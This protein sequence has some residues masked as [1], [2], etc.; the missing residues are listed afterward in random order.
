VMDSLFFPMKE[1]EKLSQHTC[2]KKWQVDESASELPEIGQE[3]SVLPAPENIEKVGSFTSRKETESKY[4]EEE[5]ED[6][7][8]RYSDTKKEYQTY[9]THYRNKVLL[10]SFSSDEEKE[11]NF[12]SSNLGFSGSD[13]GEEGIN[14]KFYF[15]KEEPIYELN[16]RGLEN[17]EHSELEGLL[18]VYSDLF[19]W[20]SQ[21][22]EQTN[23]VTHIIRTDNA[24]I[25]D[26]DTTGPLSKKKNFSKK[27]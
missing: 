17:K 6:K 5:L 15:D 2:S 9:Y 26:S 24:H 7:I 10:S 18:I 13:D 16:I 23:L 8:F 20:I 4:E 21:D 11:E 12:S 14:F 25:L 19:A 3:A 1:T 27:S 22:L